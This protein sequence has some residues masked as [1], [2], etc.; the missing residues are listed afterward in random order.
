MFIS[1]NHMNASIGTWPSLFGLEACTIPDAFG[2]TPSR[3]VWS[4]NV[5]N[6]TI[7]MVSSPEMMQQHLVWVCCRLR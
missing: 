3:S 5:A 2:G 4:E 1:A 6:V 7:F